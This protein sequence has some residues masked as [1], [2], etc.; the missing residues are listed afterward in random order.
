[1]QRTVANSP[2]WRWAM[3][4]LSCGRRR[5]YVV[6]M[7]AGFTAMVVCFGLNGSRGPTPALLVPALVL[8]AATGGC[9]LRLSFGPGSVAD[10]SSG[11]LDERQRAVLDRAYH[12]AY[13]V[14]TL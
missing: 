11:A 1:M 4:P 12:R 8:F 2:F 6:A 14:L 7:Y 10:R 5:A 13:Q 3:H 9:F